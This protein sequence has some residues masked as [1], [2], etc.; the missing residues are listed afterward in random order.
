M[1]SIVRKLILQQVAWSRWIDRLL[2]SKFSTD[3]G[4]A[5]FAENYLAKLITANSRV[6]D[7]GGGRF[8]AFTRDQ[9]SLRNLQIIGLDLNPAELN[10][11]PPGVYDRVQAADITAFQ[12]E[13]DADFIVSQMLLEHVRDT[14]KAFR[15]FHT[16]LKPGGLALIVVPCRNAAFARLNMFL[17]QSLKRRLLVFVDP[18][19]EARGAGWPAFYDRCTPGDFRT[20]AKENGFDV[21]DLR[22]FYYSAYFQICFPLH[23]IWR[24]W[25]LVA[26]AAM[27]EQAAENF[28]ICIRKRS[29]QLSRNDTA[30]SVDSVA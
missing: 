29:V 1:L 15:A 4:R 21:V 13:G 6:Y 11:A 2:P 24:L 3:V 26:D 19:T 18:L 5:Y 22:A 12:G 25:G 16:I 10:A 14:S 8:P 20:L 28:C 30:L 17:P 23:V 9:K 7:V 27:G